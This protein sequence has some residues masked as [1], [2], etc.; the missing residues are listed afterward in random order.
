MKTIGFYVSPGFQ[1][2]DLAGPAAAFEA[3][4]Q[5]FGG[6]AYR[7]AVLAADAGAVTTWLI[8]ALGLAVVAAASIRWI[9]DA[10]EAP[11]AS[12]IPP[13]VESVTRATVKAEVAREADFRRASSWL[14]RLAILL[15][16]GAFASRFASDRVQDR[17]LF[18]LALLLVVCVLAWVEL[19]AP[20]PRAATAAA[21]AIA[22]ALVLV[23]PYVKF[24][25]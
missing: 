21:A 2:L 7:V 3:A 4:S 14:H 5:E 9:R 24:I 25:G 15:A 16:V 22:L 18:F 6:P 10:G 11:Q 13:Q 12:A 17:Y 23:F 8:S 20:R 1:M 19:A